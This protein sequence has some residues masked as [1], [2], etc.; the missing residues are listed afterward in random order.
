LGTRIAVDA[1]GGDRAPGEIVRGAVDACSGDCEILLVGRRAS[2]VAELEGIGVR[3]IP[4]LRVVDAPDTVAMDEAPT[5]ALRQ[6]ES[7]LYRAI[8]MVRTGEADAAVSAGNSGAAMAIALMT[9]GRIAGIERP[10]IATVWPRQDGL[11]T[12]LL[13]AGANVDCSAENLRQ[14]ALMGRAFSEGVCHIQ[15]PRV[16]LLSIGEEDSKGNA[17][18]KEAAPLLR[19]APVNFIGNVEGRHIFSGGADVI[20]CDGFTGNVTL[21]VAEATAE[22][23][24]SLL[25]AEI[26]KSPNRTQLEELMKPCVDQVRVRTDYDQYGGAPLLGVN[27]VVIIGHGRSNARAVRNAVREAAEAVRYGVVE[28]IRSAAA[29]PTPVQT[30]A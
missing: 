16:A 30:A 20:V 22:A 23:F 8:D 10:A 29:T 14:F 7:S 13:D 28:R 15:N 9:L 4:N 3:E 24:A 2:V 19:S 1:M 18:T 17:L 6:R 12:V 26:E 25:L 21:K 5:R 27:G 11:E